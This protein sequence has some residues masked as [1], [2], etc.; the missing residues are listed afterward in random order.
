ML[1]NP[2]SCLYPR[3]PVLNRGK[4]CVLSADFSLTRF[5]VQIRKT[6][7]FKG[8]LLKHKF[9]LIPLI[10]YMSIFR[11]GLVYIC[12]GFGVSTTASCNEAW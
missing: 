7:L 6:N 9:F 11:L 10:A 4:H 12:I 8:E 1:A 3:M 2:V 5:S